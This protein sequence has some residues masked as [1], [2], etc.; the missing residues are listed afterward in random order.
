MAEQLG[1]NHK[2]W[3]RNRENVRERLT[4]SRLATIKATGQ[5][6]AI[7]QRPP[8]MTRLTTPPHT[9]RVARPQREMVPPHKAR[10]RMIILGSIFAIAAIFACAV[11][12][13]LASGMLQSSGPAVVV[14]DFFN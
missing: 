13:L 10:R 1:K 2:S 4:E 14:N 3:E 9:P 12:V 6:H 8:S 7:P 5:S 11:G